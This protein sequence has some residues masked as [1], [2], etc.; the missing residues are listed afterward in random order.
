[1]TPELIRLA[2]RHHYEIAEG[3][4]DHPNSAR[5]E[6]EVNEGLDKFFNSQPDPAKA[7]EDFDLLVSI[8]ASEAGV[9][10]N[11]AESTLLNHWIDEYLT[12]R[13]L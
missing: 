2:R 6:A 1:M 5:W 8:L 7:R 3:F 4:C 10:E 11:V 9:S 13:G 12:R